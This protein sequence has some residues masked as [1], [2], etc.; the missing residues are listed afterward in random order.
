MGRMIKAHFIAFDLT[1]YFED[2]LN[3]LPLRIEKEE[4]NVQI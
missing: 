2:W 4:A 1:T 3:Y